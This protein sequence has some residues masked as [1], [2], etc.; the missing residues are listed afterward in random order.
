M[1]S[2]RGCIG[3]RGYVGTEEVKE[4]I[5]EAP[6]DKRIEMKRKVGLCSTIC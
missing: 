2:Y 4:E 3:D 5:M 1:Y 6:V